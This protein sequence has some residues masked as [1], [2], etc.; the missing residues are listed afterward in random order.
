MNDHKRDALRYRWLRANALSVDMPHYRFN[1]DLPDSRLD[2][3]IDDEMTQTQQDLLIIRALGP[4][5]RT[6]TTDP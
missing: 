1:R 3:M 6:F 5:R 4:T 2:E